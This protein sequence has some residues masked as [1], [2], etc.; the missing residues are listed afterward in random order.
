MI[1]AAITELHQAEQTATL[2]AQREA[3]PSLP[4]F[5]EWVPAN[6]GCSHAQATRYML[7]AQKCCGAATFAETTTVHE[8]LYGEPQADKRARKKAEAAASFTREDA[9]YALKILAMAERGAT[10]GERVVA[11]VLTS[12]AVSQIMGADG[13]AGVLLLRW[14]PATV[15]EGTVAE[16]PDVAG[17]LTGPV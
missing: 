5:K 2:N 17:R 4:V 3:N 15:G 7:A 10:E 6:C 13:L 8:L 1:G 9:E 14:P 16:M 11:G 12:F